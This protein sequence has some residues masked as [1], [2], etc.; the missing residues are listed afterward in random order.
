M[1]PIQS[2][3][4]G[5]FLYCPLLA[6]VGGEF[7]TVTLKYTTTYGDPLR[8]G[9]AILIPFGGGNRM[10]ASGDLITF[11]HVPYGLYTLRASVPG[12]ETHN[13]LLRVY[14]PKQL[15]VVGLWVASLDASKRFAVGGRV[16]NYRDNTADL[17]I[18]LLPL[19]NDEILDCPVDRTGAFS[20]D[21]VNSGLYLITVLRELR[22]E[23][24]II[25]S[26]AMWIGAAESIVID[27]AEKAGQSVR[28]TKQK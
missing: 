21:G 15:N 23:V 6:Q 16:T 20:F 19:Y 1:G 25:E 2:L 5:V 4:I 18:R 10:E 3:A 27:L 8:N 26:R 24:T 7:A 22:D 11:A 14:Q 13:Q 9:R 12:F 17:R 28:R